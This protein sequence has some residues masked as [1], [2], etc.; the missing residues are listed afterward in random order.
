MDTSN[1]SKWSLQQIKNYKQTDNTES[2]IL[3]LHDFGVF[4]IDSTKVPHQQR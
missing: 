2:A 4:F 3:S 1:Q